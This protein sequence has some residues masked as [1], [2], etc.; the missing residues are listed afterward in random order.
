MRHKW[1]IK[2]PTLPDGSKVETGLSP[3]YDDWIRDRN[4]HVDLEVSTTWIQEMG[5]WCRC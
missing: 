3:R 1:A 5:S 4:E 2:L